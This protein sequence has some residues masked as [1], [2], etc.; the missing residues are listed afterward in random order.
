[1]DQKHIRWISSALSI[2]VL[3]WIVPVIL[4]NKDIMINSFICGAV[5]CLMNWYLFSVQVGGSRPSNIVNVFSKTRRGFRGNNEWFA[6]VDSSHGKVNYHHINVNSRITGVPD[7]HISLPGWETGLATIIAR[8]L[9]CIQNNVVLV[10][11]LLLIAIF[12]KHKNNQPKEGWY[13]EMLSIGVGGFSSSW[14]G[15]KIG[16]FIFPGIGTLVGTI[17]GGVIGGGV[18]GT[19]YHFCF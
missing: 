19:L 7:P 12:L 11:L 8:F 2:L 6:R 16:T 18:V 17:Y 15:G 14:L 5:G 9:K 13:R 10:T 4:G 1:M 3:F